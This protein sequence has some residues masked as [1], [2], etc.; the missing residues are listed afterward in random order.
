[1]RVMLKPLPVLVACAGCAEHGNFA[2]EAA[3]ELDRRGEGDRVWLGGDA[4][5]A[6]TKA[7]SRWPVF[8]LDACAKGC[9]RAWCERQGVTPQRCYILDGM[10]IPVL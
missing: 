7:R 10:R 9:A 5:A 8:S 6:L 3:A 4:H 2:A 1:M